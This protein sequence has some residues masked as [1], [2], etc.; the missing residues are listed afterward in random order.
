[1]KLVGTSNFGKGIIEIEVPLFVAPLLGPSTMTNATQALSFVVSTNNGV[2]KLDL[3][4]PN[5]VRLVT[6]VTTD[7][8]SANTP[9]LIAKYL[10]AYSATPGNWLDLGIS[11]V[12]ASLFT[13]ATAAGVSDSGWIQMAAG[14]KIDN[15]FV[16]IMQQ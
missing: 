14:A 4:G 6:N 13:G 7:S 5:Q 9:V 1:M 10:S 16:A 12:T 8:N 11:A 15:C 2:S 3:A